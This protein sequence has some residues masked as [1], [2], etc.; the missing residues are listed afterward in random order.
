[1]QTSPE[2]EPF[3]KAAVT[4][5]GLRAL[6]ARLFPGSDILVQKPRGLFFHGLLI[7][8][9]NGVE[10]GLE[11]TAGLFLLPFLNAVQ[12]LAVLG[13][14]MLDPGDMLKGEKADPVKI[15]LDTLHQIP[16]KIRT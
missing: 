2:T 15:A 10:M 3:K 16:G 13:T 11:Q 7:G 6:T 9:R 4:E 14:E 12:D 1:M 5:T 8:F